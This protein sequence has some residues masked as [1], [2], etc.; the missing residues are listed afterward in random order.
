MTYF[1]YEYDTTI[2]NPSILVDGDAG[3][4]AGNLVSVCFRNETK[5]E[6]HLAV[7]TSYQTGGHL[8]GIFRNLDGN[9]LC[10]KRVFSTEQAARNAK[11]EY[12][13][14]YADNHQYQ[15]SIGLTGLVYSDD[16][17]EI[18]AA[19]FQALVDG[20]TSTHF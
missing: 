8:L 7:T 12:D 20:T 1:V 3:A 15:Q 14:V 6:E 9:V 11:Q 5:V 13:V 19:E 18:T 16:I 4:T 2:T 10:T 17:Y